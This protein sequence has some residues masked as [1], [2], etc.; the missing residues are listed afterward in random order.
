MKQFAVIPIRSLIVWIT[1]LFFKKMSDT[2]TI[3]AEDLGKSNYLVQISDGKLFRSDIDH[4]V[5]NNRKLKSE[6]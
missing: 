3:P 6:A 5:F 4:F 1:V 2:F